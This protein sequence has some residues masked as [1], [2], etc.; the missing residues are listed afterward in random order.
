MALLRDFAKLHAAED[1]MDLRLLKVRYSR[2]PSKAY[3]D[4]MHQ[5]KL[6]IRANFDLDHVDELPAVHFLTSERRQ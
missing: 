6:A 1:A 2:S 4:S 5:E 3:R